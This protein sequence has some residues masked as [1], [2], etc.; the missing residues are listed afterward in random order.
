MSSSAGAART[1]RH[2]STPT[3]PEQRILVLDI[4]EILAANSA[5]IFPK[6]LPE[7]VLETV[8]LQEAS[9]HVV[10]VSKGEVGRYQL[11]P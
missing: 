10:G 8:V 4:P 3:Q 2:A 1:L 6:I 5:E 7:I 11:V 9:A